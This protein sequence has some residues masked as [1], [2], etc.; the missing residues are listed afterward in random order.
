MT[1][2]Y[3]QFFLTLQ[4]LRQ[5]IDIHLILLSNIVRRPESVG[6]DLNNLKEVWK[7]C[8]IR[9]CGMRERCA[10]NAA[11]QVFAWYDDLHVMR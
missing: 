10:T 1:C 6:F 7:V 5:Y 9:Q 4:H 3:Y 8:V 11:E 2:I